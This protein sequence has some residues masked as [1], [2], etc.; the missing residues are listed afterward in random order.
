MADETMYKSKVDWWLAVLIILLFASGI[1]YL[2]ACVYFYFE[3]GVIR[4]WYIVYG[5]FTTALIIGLVWPIY[6]VL[7]ED[8]LFIRHGLVRSTYKYSIMSMVKPSRNPLSSPALSLDRL[9]IVYE[10][11]FGFFMI[12]PQDKEG[13]MKDLASRADHLEYVDGIVKEK[14]E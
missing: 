3:T 2:G 14:G 9:M 4:W 10:G 13:F 8:S 1:A 7:K 11:T 12:S 6:Y 5:V